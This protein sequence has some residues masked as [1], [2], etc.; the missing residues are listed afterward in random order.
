[1]KSPKPTGI[2]QAG[3]SAPDFE[4][5]DLAG[6]KTRLQDR[7]KNGPV[8]LAFFKISCPTC[9]LTL[10]FLQRLADAGNEG[11]PQVI[12]VS[13]DDAASTRE[14]Q[15]R[16]RV[17][18]PTLLDDTRAWPASNGFR[19]SSVPSLFLVEPEGRISFS[20]EGFSK[21]GLKKLGE[22]FQTEPFR[23]GENVPE[24]RPG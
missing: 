5:P 11:A 9:Q 13:Q 15:N 3:D 6:A 21:A 20:T 19:I 22:R 14:F 10:P 1:M 17:S 12:A 23:P 7:L 2:L 8:L 4:L 16:F 18:M 24:L